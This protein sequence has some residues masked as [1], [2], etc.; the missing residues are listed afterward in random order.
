MNLYTYINS[1]NLRN[2]SVR[3]KFVLFLIFER[4]WGKLTVELNLDEELYYEAKLM[5]NCWSSLRKSKEKDFIYLNL[6][7]LPK[8]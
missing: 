7:K 3:L 5:S 6:I 2:V 4:T 1:R 8:C